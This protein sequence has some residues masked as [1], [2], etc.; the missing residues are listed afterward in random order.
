MKKLKL[1]LAL[2]TLLIC[3]ITNAQ[4]MAKT[5]GVNDFLMAVHFP[6]PNVGFVVGI[7]GTILKTTDIGE[8]WN[9]V[10]SNTNASF[11]SVYFINESVGF[12]VGNNMLKTI[13]GGNSWELIQP[14]I[15]DINKITFITNQMGFLITSTSLYK[16]V[17]G[18]NNWTL[19]SSMPCM[20]ISF[21]STNVGYVHGDNN[22]IFKTTDG[23]ETWTL[24]TPNANPGNISIV[25][26]MFF[27]AEDKGF[28]GGYYYG[29]FTKTL[30]GGSVWNCVNTDCQSD[31]GVGIRSIYFSSA[32]IGYAV[33]QSQNNILKTVDG[34]E[35][36]TSQNIAEA[37]LNDV[38]FSD[39]NVGFI[40]GSSGEIFK[41]ENGG[42]LG[43]AATSPDTIAIYPN[44]TANYLRI[45]VD[46]NL[47]FPIQFKL[48]NIL[49]ENLIDES[50]F[51]NSNSI[52]LSN[53]SKGVYVY[54]LFNANNEIVKIGKII[55]E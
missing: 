51:S 47:M 34:G 1:N 39:E 41:T 53:Y 12:A 48:N 4:W 18:G 13:D 37:T 32:T 40:V 17:D 23:G 30:D 38:F 5:T 10:Y 28:F 25:S 46:S 20:S 52:D 35:T 43:V 16:T 44:P 26:T 54:Q 11:K 14:F 2:I 27:T 50:L 36:W 19:K 9:T 31:I 8:T 15:T 22:S 21:P 33:C 45:D 6:S 49:G 24:S 42:N 55:K 29:A 7:G 3:S